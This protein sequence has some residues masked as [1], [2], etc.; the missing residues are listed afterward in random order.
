MGG[1]GQVKITKDGNTLLHEMQIQHPTAAMIGRAATAQDDIVGDGT[2]SNVLFI[3]ELMRQAERY[4]GEGVHPRVLVDGIEAAKKETLAYLETA[5]ITRP[6]GV[7]KDLLLDVARASLMTKVH[8]VIANPLTEIVVEAVQTIRKEDRIDLHM[9]EI[10]HMQHKMSTESRLIKGLVLDH[11][12]R[13]EGMPSR[14]ENCYIMTLNVSLEYEKTEVHSGF[15]WSN[16][17]QREKLIASERAFTDEKVQ[18][19]IDFK[20]RLCDGTNKNFVVIN[21]K[22]I[23]PPSLEMLAREGII[24]IRRA[25][26]RNMERLPLACGG[27]GL[28][29]VDDMDEKDLGFAKLVYE[30][31]LGDDKYTFIEGVENPF[32]CTILIKGPNDYSIAQVKDAIRDG[33]RAVTNTISDKCVVAGAGAFEVG[34]SCHLIEWMKKGVSGKARLGVQAFADALLVIPRTLAE[35]SGL[36]QQE[37][38]LKVVEAHEK[39]GE[40]YGV[41]TITGEAQPV[42]V[43]QVWDNYIVKRQFLN[44]APVLAEQLL[45]VDEV[46]RAGKNMNRG[47]GPEE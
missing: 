37:T 45:L 46:M 13:H 17:E 4:L 20:K 31:S 26:R 47:E 21:Q 3:G 34:A 5:R 24:G 25:K 27:K 14:V 22:G 33:L 18:K 28:N 43:S 29:S 35:N 32:S 15:F 16:A 11:G 2:T 40:A 1:A 10:M 42:A 19:I 7:T 12:G 30:V 44:I 8:P 9:I 41:D 36:D 39:T 38:L 23:D 6:E